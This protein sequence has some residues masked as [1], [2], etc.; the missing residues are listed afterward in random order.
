VLRKSA[1][2]RAGCEQ[3]MHRCAVRCTCSPYSS[4]HCLQGASWDKKTACHVSCFAF[5]LSAL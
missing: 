2:A 5:G 3:S 1:L 4:Y